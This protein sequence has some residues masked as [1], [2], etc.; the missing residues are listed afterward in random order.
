VAILNL[1]VPPAT[2]RELPHLR[3]DVV[4]AHHRDGD[5]APRRRQHQVGAHR[6]HGGARLRRHHVEALRAADGGGGGR[7][8]LGEGVVDDVRWC[9]RTPGPG[10]RR[11]GP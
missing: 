4:A 8:P 7:G 11:R 1:P 2:A 3:R 10:W 6:Q 5:L 9:P